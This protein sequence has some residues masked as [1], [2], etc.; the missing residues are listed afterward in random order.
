MPRKVPK[1]TR[2]IKMKFTCIRQS[3]GDWYDDKKPCEEAVEGTVTLYMERT[4]PKEELIKKYPYE[5]Y[6]RCINFVDDDGKI[7][8]KSP[9]SQNCYL[10]EINSLEQLMSFINKYGKILIKPAWCADDTLEADLPAIEIF[11]VD[12]EV[13]RSVDED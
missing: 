6:S 10:I 3:F 9:S 7:R 1:Q 13:E 4:L 11:D 8:C 5:D 2:S 12:Y